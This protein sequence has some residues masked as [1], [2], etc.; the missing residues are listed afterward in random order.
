MGLFRR[1][2]AIL[3]ISGL[4]GA[5]TSDVSGEKIAVKGKSAAASR[6]V[7]A[8]SGFWARLGKERAARHLP[9]LK[10]DGRLSE[11]AAKWS[12]KMSTS[13]QFKHSNI[14]QLLGPYNYVGENISWGSAGITTA[15]LHVGLMKSQHHRDNMLAPG[16]TVGGVGVYCAP[17]HSMWMTT[18]FGRKTSQGQ[19]SFGPSTSEQPIVATKPGVKC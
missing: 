8:R 3:V 15:N 18:V 12:K 5:C 17:N 16:F 4:L 11:Y 6:A 7:R 19:P 9:P 13:G 14:G 10:W 2:L 1:I